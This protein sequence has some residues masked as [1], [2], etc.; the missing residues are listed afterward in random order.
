MTWTSAAPKLA[1]QDWCSFRR[2][3]QLQWLSLIGT[4]VSDAGLENLK[5]LTQLRRLDLRGTKVSDAGLGHLKGLTRLQ[6]LNLN[7]TKASDA[8]VGKLKR[9]LP[10]CYIVQ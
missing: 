10:G 8:G 5:G 3:T 6:G 2:L 4:E 1:T 7:G 9:A